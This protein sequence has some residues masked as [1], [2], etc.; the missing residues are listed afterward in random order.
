MTI[1]QIPVSAFSFIDQLRQNNDRNW[2]ALNK[3]IYQKE[4]ANV[5][6]FVDGLLQELNKHDV[7]ETP[8]GVRSLYRIYRDIRFSQDKTPYSTYWGGRFKRAGSQR[9]GG[10]YYHF[11]PGGRSFLLCGFWGPNALDLKLIRDEIVYDPRPLMEIIGS[12]AF[13]NNF[14]SLRGEQLKTCPKGYEKTHKAIDLLRHKQFL[15]RKQFSDAEVLS[16]EFLN[17]ANDSLKNMRPFLDYMSETLTLDSNG[18]II[19]I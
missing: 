18:L 9:R 6:A 19:K 5:A 16:P 14:G 2:F 8:T 1:I 11:E 15:V 7:I 13:I 12:A 10:Y 4:A 17:I 3:A